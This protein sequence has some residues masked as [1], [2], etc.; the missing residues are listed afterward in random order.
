MDPFYELDFFSHKFY[1]QVTTYP[2]YVLVPLPAPTADTHTQHTPSSLHELKYSN[3]NAL[4]SFLLCNVCR[5]QIKSHKYNVITIDLMPNA[6]KQFIPRRLPTTQAS[7]RP[8]A[9][10]IFSST[11]YNASPAIQANLPGSLDAILLL[12]I[13]AFNQYFLVELLPHKC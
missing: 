12:A 3:R 11:N 13:A 10:P 4:L 2:D 9:P 6:T 8:Q 1:L 5:V 7:P